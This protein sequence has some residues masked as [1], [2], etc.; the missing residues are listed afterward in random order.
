VVANASGTVVQANHYYPFGMPFT[1]G[2]ATSSQPYKYNGKELDTERGLNLYD[3]GARLYDPAL[4]RW[5]TVDPLEELNVSISPSVYC[6]DNPINRIDPTGLYDLP[7]V[8]VIGHKY[9]TSYTDSFY[10]E[11]MLSYWSRAFGETANLGK[12][13]TV[14]YTLINPNLL[15]Q[16]YHTISK[17]KAATKMGLKSGKMF[18]KMKALTSVSSKLSRA[19]KGFGIAGDVLSVAQIG[20]DISDDSIKPSSIYSG[21]MVFG[22]YSGRILCWSRNCC[23]TCNLRSCRC[24]F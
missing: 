2:N 6:S 13:L 7:E 20:V 10:L 17:T 9:T 8:V 5:T 11:N 12:S 4:A 23:W 3:Y 15:R 16:T 24:H 21:T 18:Q 1:E 22:G 14:G 19:I